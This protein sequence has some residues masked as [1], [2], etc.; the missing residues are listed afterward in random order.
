MPSDERKYVKVRKA[1]G[2]T[3]LML[4]RPDKRNAMSPELHYEMD[5]T[6]AELET[7]PDTHV[8]V[9]TGAGE[10]F[11]AGQDLQKFFRELD[12][13][14]AEQKRAGEAADRWRWYR[15]SM[16]DKPTIAMVNG[17]CVGGAFIQ[18][19][20][21]DFAIAADTATF[22]LSEINWGI[23]PGSLVSKVVADA[24]LYRH[25]LYYACLG[26]AFTARRAVEIGL[27]NAAVPAAELE[28]ETITLAGRLMAKNPEVLRGT[29]QAIRMVRDMDHQRANEYMRIKMAEVKI[30]DRERAR[31]AGIAQ[32]IDDKSFKP[33]FEPARRHYFESQ[34][35]RRS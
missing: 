33:T 14:P 25:A 27:I 28:R 23:L 26:E 21:C 3:W 30:R 15:L 22:S 8:L 34:E 5:A 17:Y 19:L 31:D 4:N 20:A 7:D 6:L 16:Y 10:A 9:L 1:E 2:I 29:K 18:L 13:K 12:D 11:S 35:G 24:V 32:F